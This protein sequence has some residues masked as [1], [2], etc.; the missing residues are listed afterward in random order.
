MKLF[1][2]TIGNEV[3]VN[4]MEK[5]QP[6]GDVVTVIMHASL[7]DIIYNQLELGK[8]PECIKIED[9]RINSPYPV[10][11]C[12]IWDKERNRC[13]VAIGS[14]KPETLPAGIPS[15]Y[16]DETASNRAFDRAA[17]VY[18]QFPGRNLSDEELGLSIDYSAIGGIELPDVAEEPVSDEPLPVIKEAPIKTQVVD[19]LAGAMN[20]P[21][22]PDEVEKP[23]PAAKTSNIPAPTPPVVDSVTQAGAHIVDF[24]K[25]QHNP[26][27]V[28]EIC[29]ED[30]E[31]VDKCLKIS[32]PNENIKPHIDALRVYR[33]SLS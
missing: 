23:T 21:V 20:P 2:K 32:R 16:A 4:T 25:Y 31:W 7:Q 30:L 8:D 17:L 9:A 27:T 29:A 28:A 18:L 15:D 12:T 3:D 1:S 11:K 5:A 19:P 6:N 10:Y 14:A 22:E 26:K 33:E 13:S 24:G